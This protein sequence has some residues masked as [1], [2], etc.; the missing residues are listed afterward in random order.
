MTTPVTPPAVILPSVYPPLGSVTFN[1]DAY[2]AATSLPG[3]F[4]RQGEIAIATKT[5]ADSAAESA[6]AAQAAAV[7]AVGSSE[8]AAA[9]ANFKGLWPSLT[10]A[11]NKPASVKHNGRFWLLLNNLAN[12]A[13]SEPGVTA[14]WTSLNV[15]QVSARISSNTNAVPGV[16]YVV[17]AVGVTLTVRTEEGWGADDTVGG[18]NASGGDCFINWTTYT[19]VG[20]T[21]DPPMT[22]P[23]RGRFSAVFDGSTFA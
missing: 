17:T 3:A 13:A 9:A 7:S 8:Q 6:T 10:G 19:L 5:N 14:D 11:L 15:G 18:R 4:T 1:Q 20:E 23:R 2:N 12:V 16:Y 21:P 22:W